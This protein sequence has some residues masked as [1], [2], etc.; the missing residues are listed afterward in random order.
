MHKHVEYTT[1]KTKVSKGV[2]I[3]RTKVNK[4]IIRNLLVRKRIKN[5][6]KNRQRE[7]TFHRGKIRGQASNVVEVYE[8]LRF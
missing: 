3:D 5:C 2:I 1:L 4:N 6:T 7:V 8:K